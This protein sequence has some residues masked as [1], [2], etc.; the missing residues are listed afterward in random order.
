[1]IFGDE[2]GFIS[3]IDVRKP[4]EATKLIVF[5]APVHKIVVQPESVLI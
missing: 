4:G 3:L 2:A 5:P 1:M